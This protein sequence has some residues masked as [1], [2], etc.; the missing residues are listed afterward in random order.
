M[1]ASTSNAD[2]RIAG[3]ILAAGSAQRMGE[4]KQ[5]LPLGD[6][7]LVQHVIDASLA[8]NLHEVV[9]VLGHASARIRSTLRREVSERLS[10]VEI[11][12][13]QSGA[14]HSLQVGLGACS[15]QVDAALILLADQPEVDAGLIEQMLAAYSNS[16]RAAVRPFWRDATGEALPGHPVVLGRTIW[17]ELIRSPGEAGAGPILDAEP[18]WLEP[19][20]LDGPRPADIDTWA[21]YRRA[22][23]G[24]R[25]QRVEDPH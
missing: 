24:A 7:P 9:L 23:G 17:P 25:P 2:A 18:A 19:I 5:L 1:D 21:D 12:A 13:A 22:G 20:R 6:K 4:P 8:A 14:G 10:I 11:E 16:S 3:V 15:A